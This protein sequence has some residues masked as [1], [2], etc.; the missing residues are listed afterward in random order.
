MISDNIYAEMPEWTPK[1]HR[2]VAAAMGFRARLLMESILAFSGKHS[3]GSMAEDERLAI[4][5]AEE[6]AHSAFKSGEAV[7][8][9]G[10]PLYR[11][12][13]A[14]ESADGG[15]W[16]VTEDFRQ[17]NDD[18]AESE[19]VELAESWFNFEPKSTRAIKATITLS[20]IDGDDEELVSTIDCEAGDNCP[21][22]YE[23]RSRRQPQPL[24]KYRIVR[25]VSGVHVIEQQNESGRWV[26]VNDSA[27][28][29]LAEAQTKLADV[30]ANGEPCDEVIQ[31]VEA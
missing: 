10:L 8:Q 26:F 3:D 1:Q 24:R 5:C 2:A 4:A 23:H 13:L 6:A 7:R 9:V 28:S 21:T 20:Q 29:T 31:E 12:A 25:R 22:I 27:V 30:I 17:V 19:A 16:D 18:A 11:A 14:L 15:S